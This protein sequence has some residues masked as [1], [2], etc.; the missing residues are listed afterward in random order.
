MTDKSVAERTAGAVISMAS[1]FMLDG[2][3]YEV[4]GAAGFDGMDFYAAGGRGA[5]G[6]LRRG[7]GGGPL[8]AADAAVV[9]APE[10]AG[11]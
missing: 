5:G 1:H 8:T 11:A 9:A 6:A 2:A 7:E 3:T 10:Y 4:G